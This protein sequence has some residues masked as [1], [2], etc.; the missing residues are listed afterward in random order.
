MINARERDVYLHNVFLS[1]AATHVGA[2]GIR[3]L[4][5][6]RFLPPCVGVAPLGLELGVLNRSHMDLS[7]PDGRPCLSRETLALVRAGSQKLLFTFVIEVTRLSQIVV[8]N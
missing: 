7:G 2:V 3:V 4:P 8:T 6:R 5:A 1:R